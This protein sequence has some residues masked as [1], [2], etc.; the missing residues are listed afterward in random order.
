M[1]CSGCPADFIMA[2]TWS[3]VNRASAERRIYGTGG[4]V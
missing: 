4:N 2:C 1:A 3:V